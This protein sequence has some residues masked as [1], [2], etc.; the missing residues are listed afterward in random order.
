MRTKE[1]RGSISYLADAVRTASS[2]I[3][4]NRLRSFLTV[5]IV[6]L[7][8]TCLVGSQTAIDCLGSLLAGAFGTSAGKITITSAR[9]SSGSGQRTAT[10][11]SYCE[12]AGFKAAFDGGQCSIY[13]CA[14]PLTEVGCNG[15]RLAPQTTVMAFDGDYFVCNGLSVGE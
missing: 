11:I 9:E 7:G 12:A 8:V 15:R 5:V 10:P 3:F 14:S 2:N 6:A 1:T 13:T 4:N